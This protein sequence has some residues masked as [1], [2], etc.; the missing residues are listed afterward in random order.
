MASKARKALLLACAVLSVMGLSTNALAY[1]YNSNTGVAPPSGLVVPGGT[2]QLTAT[3]QSGCPPFEMCT[4]LTGVLV[5]DDGDVGG[6]FS[7]PSCTFKLSDN[8]SV[9]TCATIYSAPRISGLVL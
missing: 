8:L 3:V 9:G 7:T 5:W 2:L 6:S 4:P 1:S